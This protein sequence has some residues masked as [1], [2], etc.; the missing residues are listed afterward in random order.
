[1]ERGLQAV[2]AQTTSL[3]NP[4]NQSAATVTPYFSV[5]EAKQTRRQQE[6]N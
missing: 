6:S 2:S 3:G 5:V 4:V 1:V